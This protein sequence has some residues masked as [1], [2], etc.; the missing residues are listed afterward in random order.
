MKTVKEI[1][2]DKKTTMR[3]FTIAEI[4]K[5]VEI[6]VKESELLKNENNRRKRVVILCESILE[7]AKIFG[8]SRDIRIAHTALRRKQLPQDMKNIEFGEEFKKA[9]FYR[10]VYSSLA[11]KKCY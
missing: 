11:G 2:E 3:S 6:S 4:E 5:M 1:W 9:Q 8:S 10:A 7:M